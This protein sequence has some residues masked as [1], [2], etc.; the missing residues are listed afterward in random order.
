MA[1]SSNDAYK[2]IHES[3]YAAVEAMLEDSNYEESIE[4]ADMMAELERDKISFIEYYDVDFGVKRV[5][6]DD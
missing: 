4:Y 6:N 3:L 2:I 1:K 5:Y